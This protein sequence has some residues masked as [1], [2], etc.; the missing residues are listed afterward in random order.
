[1]KF[2]NMQL[3]IRLHVYIRLRLISMSVIWSNSAQKSYEHDWV[4]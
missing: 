2:V 4:S 1:M 3:C